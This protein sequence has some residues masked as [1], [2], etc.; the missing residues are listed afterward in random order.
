MVIQTTESFDDLH[1][2][3]DMFWMGQNTNHL[4]AHPLVREALIKGV[5]EQ[6]YN[7]YAPP[8]GMEKLREQVLTDLLGDKASNGTQVLITDGAV[9]GLYLSLIHISEPT[10]PY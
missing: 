6:S 1:E 10:R 9:E 3:Q 2:S 8:Q 4:P 5:R 7:L